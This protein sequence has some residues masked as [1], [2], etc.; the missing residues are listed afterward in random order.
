M[1]DPLRL[2]PAPAPAWGGYPGMGGPPIVAPR[3]KSGASF[4][5]PLPL[6]GDGNQKPVLQGVTRHGERRQLDK[7]P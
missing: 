4:F 5:G 6:R 1:T 3:A 7:T 2:D